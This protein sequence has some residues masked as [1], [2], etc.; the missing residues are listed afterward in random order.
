MS[1]CTYLSIRAMGII[2]SYTKV[3]KKVSLIPEEMI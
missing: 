2:S 3:T 1:P